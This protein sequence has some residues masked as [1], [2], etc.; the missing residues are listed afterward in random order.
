MKGCI[1]KFGGSITLCFLQLTDALVVGDNPVLKEVLDVHEKKM[2]I[3][4]IRQLMSL[5]VGELSIKDLTTSDY[6]EVVIM[7][8]EAKNIEVQRH[9]QSS[10]PDIQAAEGTAKDIF[11]GPSDDTVT[12]GDGHSNG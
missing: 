2:K 8:L 11:Q 1:E 12:A 9:S 4:N 3:I 10:H 5:I 7:M 6:P